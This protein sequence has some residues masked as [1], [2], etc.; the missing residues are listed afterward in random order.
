MNAVLDAYLRFLAD[1]SPRTNKEVLEH[2]YKKF[3]MT[4]WEKRDRTAGGTVKIKSRRNWAKSALRGNDLITYLP[5][6]NVQITAKGRDLL[7]SNDSITPADLK[8]VPGSSV[9]A[10]SGI[11]GIDEKIEDY[12][13][14]VKNAL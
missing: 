5:D 9:E 2:L 4:G 12:V 8:T 7:A 6:K 10:A 1:G 13:Q 11:E 3:E 14:V